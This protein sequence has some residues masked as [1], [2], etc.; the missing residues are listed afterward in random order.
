MT[1]LR[2][3]PVR[4]D[5]ATTKSDTQAAPRSTITLR[6]ILLGL[7]LMPVNAYWVTVV[8]VRWYSLDGSCLPLFITP[9]FILFCLA[10]INL[11]LNRLAPAQAFTQVELLVIYIMVVIGETLCG[12]DF[13]QNLFGV[14][15]HPYRF[16]TPE[17]KWEELFHQ[18]LPSW[19]VVSDETC[20][21]GFY[22]GGA[23]WWHRENL[24]PMLRPLAWWGLWL[25]IMIFALLCL[26]VLI[27]RPWTEHEKLAFPLIVLPL[28]LTRGQ[29]TAA[30]FR[31]RLMWIGFGVAVALDVLNGLH[32]F[33]PQVPGIKY[34]KQYDLHQHLHGP[35]WDYMGRFTT[36]LYPFAIGLAFF[37]PTDLSFSCWFFYVF[38][39]LELM[40]GGM[41]GWKQAQGLPYL[42]EQ[43]GGAWLA[44]AMSGL[45]AARRHLLTVWRKVIGRAD[46]RDEDE[47]FSY[48]LAF[49][50]LL[51][52]SI[53][54]MVIA[55]QAGMNTPTIIGFL[56]I[57]YLLS[58]AMTR[59]RAEFGAP[60]EIYFV[61]PHRL[62]VQMAGSQAMGV[63]NLTAL[64]TTYWFNRCYRC[65]PM[66]NQL[67]AFKMTE[68]AAI[69]R[70]WLAR[71]M[72]IA[73]AAAILVAYWSNLVVT[74]R[75]G[76]SARCQG[77]KSWVGW[78][79]YNR[80]RQWIDVPVGPDYRAMAAMAIAAIFMF[81]LKALRF[82]FTN[83]P[84][85]PAGYALAI[86]F[87]MD[88]FWFAFL[89]SWLIKVVLTRYWGMKVHRE[90]VHFFL[91]LILG[92]YV[93]G[94]IWAIL[95]PA[96]GRQ[97]YKIF[98]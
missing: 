42:N 85:H 68:Y 53:L 44:L 21:T 15:G 25:L 69:D 39:K 40:G 93:T 95:G 86:S 41:I 13:V 38:S 66:P 60:H 2:I 83:I 82:R 47:P 71:A 37:L 16:A 34:I 7:L 56:L 6:A 62:M 9:V 97:N 20:L 64:S 88:Y 29:E 50:G 98:I 55:I 10:V 70:K 63:R 48:R 72:V 67:E 91:G 32:Q 46:I 36:S 74:F 43:A 5:G 77:F 80:L 24:L 14:L 94:S 49:G 87:A 76:A 1:N 12:H 54:L 17:N 8:E 78:E 18:Y 22:E 84:F 89:V 58:L 35:P 30:F 27:R 51:L 73:T 19:L 33:F 61:N 52:G 81:V 45:W 28:E 4:Q 96:F 3:A 75:E 23:V 59:V 26:N 31:N 11:L 65:H 90:G 79:T 92:D 57:F